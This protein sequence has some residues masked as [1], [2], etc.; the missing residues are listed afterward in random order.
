[1]L[2]ATFSR[3]LP[4]LCEKKRKYGSNILWLI[5]VITIDPIQFSQES[6]TEHLEATEHVSYIK[7]W[8]TEN[9]IKSWKS[10]NSS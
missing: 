2:L 6:K 3:K 8:P 5:A 7:A 10:V 9:G 4:S 1:M